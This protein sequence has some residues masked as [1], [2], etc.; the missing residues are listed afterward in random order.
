[1]SPDAYLRL[2]DDLGV[3]DAAPDVQWEIVKYIKFEGQSCVRAA[4]AHVALSLQ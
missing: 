3:L 4:E 2:A 1:L